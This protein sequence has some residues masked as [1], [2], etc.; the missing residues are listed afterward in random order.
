MNRLPRG[1]CRARL[2][3]LRWLPGNTPANSPGCR[4]VSETIHVVADLRQD[5]AAAI[6]W[7]PGAV[8][9]TAP[10]QAKGLPA[11]SISCS[12]PADLLAPTFQQL[13]VLPHQET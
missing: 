10:T 13:P 11:R 12:N 5:R 9:S 8:I 3:A 4:A 7:I 6:F 1:L 2:P